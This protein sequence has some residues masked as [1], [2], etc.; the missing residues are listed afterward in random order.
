M[1]TEVRAE[2]DWDVRGLDFESALVCAIHD[3][4]IDA[5]RLIRFDWDNGLPNFQLYRCGLAGDSLYRPVLRDWAVA[6]AIAYAKGGKLR[7]NAYSDEFVAVAAWDAL[8]I[9]LDSQ[10]LFT[11]TAIAGDLGVDKKTYL[12]FRNNLARH[13]KA[14]LDE[15][16][17]RINVTYRQVFL[18]ERK[19]LS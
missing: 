13:W 6:Y 8:S 9:V 18:S 4:I 19:S 3:T 15:Y 16:W 11:P 2:G 7:R 10:Q 12:R 17:I 14:S 1:T 5:D